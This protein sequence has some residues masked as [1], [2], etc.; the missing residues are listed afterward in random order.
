MWDPSRL[1]LRKKLEVRCSLPLYG[2]VLDV[3]F[4]AKVSPSFPTSF[5]VGIFLSTQ[6]VDVSFSACFF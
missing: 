3:G 1:L 2:P 6:C 4:M 5:G